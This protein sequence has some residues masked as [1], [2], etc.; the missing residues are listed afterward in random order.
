MLPKLATVCFEPSSVY[1][2]RCGFQQVLLVTS[3]DKS[4]VFHRTAFWRSGVITGVTMLSRS[5]M[6][7]L[8]KGDAKYGGDGRFTQV[9]ELKQE[10][11]LSHEE[12]FNLFFVV[13]L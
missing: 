11:W 7:K 3:N 8:P 1:G 9:Q 10:T 5:E 2:A 12:C 4:N 6:I 13:M